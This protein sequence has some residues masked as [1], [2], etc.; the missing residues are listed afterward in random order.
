MCT[1]HVHT[2]TYNVRI[3]RMHVHILYTSRH[4]HIHTLS[5]SRKYLYIHTQ[6]TRDDPEHSQTTQPRTRRHAGTHLGGSRVGK[7]L[8]T[9]HGHGSVDREGQARL[10]QR[11]SVIL[12]RD[13]PA[14]QRD[15]SFQSCVYLVQRYM[16]PIVAA[17]PA[18][19]W[20]HARRSSFQVFR[21]Y[22]LSV[23]TVHGGN[24][25]HALGVSRNQRRRL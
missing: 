11:A 21:N 12:K 25:W 23:G 24:L 5:L 17:W 6:R 7:L 4:S 1:C 8:C 13:L 10:G 19:F 3:K 15:E 16:T 18:R 20:Q 2:N 22:W 9:S 14:F